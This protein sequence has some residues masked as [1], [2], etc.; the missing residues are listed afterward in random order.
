MTT[1]NETL[2]GSAPGGN[3]MSA[4]FTGNRMSAASRNGSPDSVNSNAPTNGNAPSGNLPPANALNAAGSM[5]SILNS[6]F[7]A[8]D[9]G[10]TIR[11]T[12]LPGPVDRIV[13]PDA[14]NPTVPS[15]NRCRV[16]GIWL[17]VP[18]A[19]TRT[20]EMKSSTDPR[21][22][23]TKLPSVSANTVCVS[24][25][26]SF[27]STTGRP[28][29]DVPCEPSTTIPSRSRT[30]SNAGIRPSNAGARFVD[31]GAWI[32]T[33]APAPRTMASFTVVNPNSRSPSTGRPARSTTVVATFNRYAVAAVRAFTGSTVTV[34][35]ARFS[36][37][38]AVTTAPV[39]ST[40]C[41]PPAITVAGFNARLNV[42]AT[43][44]TRATPTALFVG[45]T[46]TTTGPRCPVTT[47]A[48]TAAKPTPTVTA[49]PPESP[50][51]TSNT[52]NSEAPDGASSRYRPSA[53]VSAVHGPRRTTNPRS[54][55]P[56]ALRATPSTTASG[57]AVFKRRYWPPPS[58]P[59]NPPSAGSVTASFPA[60]S[61]TN[62]NTGWNPCC[63]ASNTARAS[64]KLDDGSTVPKS[65]PSRRP[66]ATAPTPSSNART[67]VTP[68]GTRSP[69]APSAGSRSKTASVP[70]RSP[71]C[72]AIRSEPTASPDPSGRN[73]PP[74]N[75][76]GGNTSTRIR[77][78]DN[79]SPASN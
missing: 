72:A 38:L 70:T 11:S 78:S 64:T 1:T 65:T 46:V 15:S 37:T 76:P 79:S 43:G 12:A 73:T 54:V 13:P 49:E 69:T 36:V 19:F 42:A 55:P 60:A 62:R 7:P 24:P 23:D 22:N 20:A 66:T 56:A 47:S 5:L 25:V 40:S 57:P 26:D 74:A 44:V 58:T 4:N 68:A 53:S 10:S 3:P 34:V 77:A 45:D 35:P 50:R 16:A 59:S 29:S 27:T 28:G 14:N 6:V 18:F 33:W 51:A 30:G 75:A 41:T 31:P 63:P 52:R 32:V 48:C 67:K 9:P 61:L 21:T 8:T 2:V 17:R 71:D 39:G